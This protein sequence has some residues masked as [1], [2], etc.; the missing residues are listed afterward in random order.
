[1]ANIL[2]SLAR[3]FGLAPAIDLR[4]KF[5]REI[6]IVG[7]YGYGNTGDEAQ[8]GANIS[9]WKRLRGKTELLVLSPNPRYTSKH[10]RCR[11]GYA[12]R[13]VFFYANRTTHYIRSSSRFVL[14]FW[15]ALLR[16]ELSAQFLRAGL[17][18]LFA[19]ASET[20]LLCSLQNASLLHVS[21]GGFLTGP[22]RSRLWDTCLLLRLCHRLNTP[23]VLTGQTIGL[24]ENAADRW[25]ARSALRGALLI[26]L[27]DPVESALEIQQ[28][29]IAG[30]NVISTFDDAL[31]C[32]KIDDTTLTSALLRQGLSSGE[33]Y[34]AVNYHWWGMSEEMRQ[35][36]C[37]RLAEVLATTQAR[38]AIK[39][40]LVPMV[41]SD[42]EALKALAALL[43]ADTY[44]ILDYAYE[45]P[46][47]RAV[48]AR[49]L[50]LVSFK[51]HPVIFALGESVPSISLSVDKYY[52]R[53]NDGAMGNF[54]Q[55]DFCLHRDDFLGEHFI[56]AM[57]RLLTERDTISSAISK[58]LIAARLRQDELFDQ[59]IQQA[60]LLE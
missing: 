55:H 14:T 58:Q 30:T 21:G 51:H 38:H 33:P 50:A 6:I 11:S 3:L 16:L 48:I 9:R 39:L 46:V 2:H 10:H 15:F 5:P 1:M 7:G 8:L 26:S 36:S 13:V 34:L 25:L 20:K 19:S 35:R 44:T 49:A 45:Y 32:E 53:K 18:A 59:I 4:S 42:L 28:L 23:Y 52:D 43:P 27:R 54:G 40:M 57:E 31:F 17:P 41:A 47:V 29:G 22:T 12:S 37:K 56:Q 24:F 60:G